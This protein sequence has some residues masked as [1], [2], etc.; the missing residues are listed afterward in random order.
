MNIKRVH[1]TL[2]IRTNDLVRAFPFFS[3]FD[4][5][6]RSISKKLDLIDLNGKLIYALLHS[7]SDFRLEQGILSS[8][9]AQYEGRKKFKPNSEMRGHTV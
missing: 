1:Q 5:Y 9:K 7:E 2:W 3:I 8:K 4:K 6:E